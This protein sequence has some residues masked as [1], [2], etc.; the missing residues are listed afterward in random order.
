[1]L[2]CF[3]SKLGGAICMVGAMLLLLFLPWITES[4]FES[5]DP[6]YRPLY[7]IF[8]IF[9]TLDMLL[10]GWLGGLAVS[11]NTLFLTQFCT[12]FYFFYFLAFL[13]SY[14]L[15]IRWSQAKILKHKLE[16]IN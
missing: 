14:S 7:N 2:K 6:M 4:G 16:C 12:V 15:F 8:F 9:F 13:P 5:S 1:M 10:L 3:P 11:E